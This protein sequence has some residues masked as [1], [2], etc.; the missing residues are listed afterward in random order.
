MGLVL[1]YLQHKDFEEIQGRFQKREPLISGSTAAQ[2]LRCQIPAEIISDPLH[3][4]ENDPFE[5]G[6]DLQRQH[7]VRP[8]QSFSNYIL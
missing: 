6:T 8:V 4:M 2:R 5:E 7:R 1:I 3:D